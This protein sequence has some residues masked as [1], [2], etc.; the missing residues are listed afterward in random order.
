M[1]CDFCHVLVNIPQKGE[2][3]TRHHP[4]HTLPI[5]GAILRSRVNHLP[6]QYEERIVCSTP[7]LLVFPE[8][9]PKLAG[10]IQVNSK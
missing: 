5:T 7:I 2:F 10:A 1:F 3:K 9:I 4:S 6:S 8:P